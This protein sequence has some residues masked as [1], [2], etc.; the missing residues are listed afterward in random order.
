[1]NYPDALC[2]DDQRNLCITDLNSYIDS[3]NIV[4]VAPDYRFVLGFKLHR[5]DPKTFFAPNTYD[6]FMSKS[7]SSCGPKTRTK[8]FISDLHTDLI[9]SGGINNISLKFPPYSPLTQPELLTDSD[10]CDEHSI[11]ESCNGREPCPCVHR[12]KIKL[13]SIVEMVIVDETP[14]TGKDQHTIKFT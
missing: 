11:P 9:L 12:L 1:M 8:T 3:S 14:A 4:N 10:F 13:N 7:R 6:H 5:L 2:G